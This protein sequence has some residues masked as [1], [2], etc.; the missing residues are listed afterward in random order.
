MNTNPRRASPSPRLRSPWTTTARLPL[1]L[2]C[3]S[4]WIAACWS[5]CVLFSFL[6][7]S[8]QPPPDAGAAPAAPAGARRQRMGARRQHGHTPSSEDD[9]TT[10]PSGRAPRLR[11]GRTPRAAALR[12]GAALNQSVPLAAFVY[13][14]HERSGTH[15][16]YLYVGSAT[17]CWHMAGSALSTGCL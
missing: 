17:H 10:A 13:P 5:Y 9:A 4:L 7:S 6:A 1:L 14:L 8:P 2:F 3:G 15:H 16:A 11:A 12:G